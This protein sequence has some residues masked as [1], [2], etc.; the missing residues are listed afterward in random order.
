MELPEMKYPIGYKYRPIRKHTY[1]CTVIDYRFTFDSVGNLKQ[2][3]YV[4]AHKFSGQIVI[5]YDVPKATLD[6][7]TKVIS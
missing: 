3:R 6:R 1:D 7:A 2:S 5:D 4:S